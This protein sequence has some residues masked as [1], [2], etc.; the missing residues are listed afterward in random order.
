MTAVCGH[1]NGARARLRD[2]GIDPDEAAGDAELLARTVLGWDRTTYLA[3]SRTEAPSGFI[4]RYDAALARR[5]G[6]EPV[7]LITGHKE[8]WGLEFD[9]TPDVLTPRPETEFLVEEALCHLPRLASTPLHVVDVGT[10]SGCLAVAIA[11]ERSDTRLT[12]TDVSAAALAV[13]RRNAQRHGVEDRISWMCTPFLDGVEGAPDLIVAN[14][15]YVP[16]ADLPNLPPE[17]REFEPRVALDGGADGLAMI[18]QLIEH[19]RARLVPGGHLVVEL[20]EGQ[21]ASLR[22]DIEK[23]PGL[24]CLGVRDDL[25][26]IPRVAII[27]RTAPKEQPDP[28]A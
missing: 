6:R 3:R 7:S 5:E 27:Q 2:A 21:A 15:P 4:Q 20:G 16:E 25:Q 22:T 12:A 8:F 13:A 17:V 18:R 28:G 1:I 24:A 10:G 9:V 23:Q 11:H 19:A 14:L 26:G